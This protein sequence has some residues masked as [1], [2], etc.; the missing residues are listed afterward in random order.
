MGEFCQIYEKEE[1]E[2][3]V[4]GEVVSREK[5]VKIVEGKEV[6]LSEMYQDK[7]NKILSIEKQEGWEEKK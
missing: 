1:I 6:I 4:I 2:C 7:L 3:S 5:G